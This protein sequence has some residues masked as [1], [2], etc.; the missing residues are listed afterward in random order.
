MTP[1]DAAFERWRARDSAN[2]KWWG[3]EYN[4]QALREECPTCRS[5]NKT[6]MTVKRWRHMQ[7]VTHIAAQFKVDP[8][9]LLALVMAYLILNADKKRIRE[10]KRQNGV[11]K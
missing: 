9:E 8:K 5:W 10:V 4:I 1:L 3:L 11:K 2:L 6:V 7:T